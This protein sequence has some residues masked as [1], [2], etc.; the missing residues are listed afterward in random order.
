M[1]KLAWTLF[2]AALTALLA[3]GGF[4]FDLVPIPAGAQRPAKIVVTFD[5]EAEALKEEI[6][7]IRL[8]RD[9]LAA[10]LSA[11]EADQDALLEDLGYVL[12]E[13]DRQRQR[14]GPDAASSTEAAP[15]A[16]GT[17]EIPLVPEAGPAAPV[18]PGSIDPLD[19]GLRAYRNEDYWRAFDTWM[20]LARAGNPR[21][22]FFIGGLYNDGSGVPRDLVMAYVWL[23]LSDRGG[24]PR[25]ESVL[26][27]VVRRMTAVEIDLA[28][29]RLARASF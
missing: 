11:V 9:R 5:S 14:L 10:D 19:I 12:A 8:E 6:V 13:R 22:Q 28:E 4:A 15:A 21:A 18:L 7:R 16:T 25:A 1:Y 29:S 27:A 17:S 26:E 23:R 20:P 3:L 24:H 2:G